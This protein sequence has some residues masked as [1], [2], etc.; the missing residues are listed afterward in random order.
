M[1]GCDQHKDELSFFTDQEWKWRDKDNRIQ[2]GTSRD[3]NL[4]LRK[5]NLEDQSIIEITGSSQKL[6][7]VKVIFVTNC[8]PGYEIETKERDHLGRPETLSC[9]RDGTHLLTVA[10]FFDFDIRKHGIYRKYYEGFRLDEDLRDWDFT[11]IDRDWALSTAKPEQL[12][13]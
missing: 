1:S 4:A 9:H 6:L 8:R 5:V 2:I 7:V 12:W 3:G 10:L 11:P 13:K